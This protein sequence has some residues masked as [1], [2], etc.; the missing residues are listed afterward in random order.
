MPHAAT[1][2]VVL[3]SAMCKASL[4]TRLD[5]RPGFPPRIPATIPPERARRENPSPVTLLTSAVSVR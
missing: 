5:A 2:L 4:R 1:L 3:V